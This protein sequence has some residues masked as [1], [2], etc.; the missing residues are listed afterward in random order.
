[1]HL[2]S[3][4]VSTIL[5]NGGVLYS[6]HDSLLTGM[7]FWPVPA[8]SSFVTAVAQGKQML[9]A[10]HLPES[11]S[12]MQDLEH[13]RS[14]DAK[15]GKELVTQ[16][17]LSPEEVVEVTVSESRAHK[18]AWEACV[19]V[20]IDPDWEAAQTALAGRKHGRSAAR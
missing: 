5:T 14:T 9:K 19:T 8:A 20:E 2:H 13:W 3:G 16:Q 7:S 11:A 10:L 12:A 4:P 6:E 15:P 18:K 1:M 17:K